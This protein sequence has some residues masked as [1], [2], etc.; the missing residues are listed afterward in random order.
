MSAETN[1]RGLLARWQRGEEAA[2]TLLFERYQQRL[3]ALLQS[4]LSRTL[5]RRVDPEDILLSAYRSFFTRVRNG[6]L[7][8]AAD[9][10][11]WPLL[12][13]I[14]LRKLARQAR[15]HSAECRNMASEQSLSTAQQEPPARSWPTAEESAALAEGVDRLLAA[16]DDNAREVVLLALHGATSPEIARSLHLHERTVRRILARITPRTP[17]ESDVPDR[18]DAEPLSTTAAAWQPQ[19]IPAG[20]V[21]YADYRLQQFVGAGAFSKVY[22]AIELPS[23]AVVAVKYLRKECWRDRRAWS[24]LIRE[25]ETLCRLDHPHLL[26]VSGWGRTPAGGV[27]LVSEFLGGGPL[28]DVNHAQSMSPGLVVDIVLAVSDAVAAAHQAGILHCDLKPTNILR[29]EDGRVVLCDFGLARYAAAPDDVPRGATAGYAAPESLCTAFGPLTE[30]T[31]VYGL[32]A[33]AYSLLTGRPPMIGRDLPETL[34]NVLSP[35]LP[36][37]PSTFRAD[38][39]PLLDAVVLKALAKSPADRFASVP[40]MAQQLP[41]R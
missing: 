11:V 34:S 8:P 12:V 40:D 26:R 31:D 27:F 25:Y 14:A 5:A 29:R 23:G 20:N 19:A 39:P 37:A 18:V 13:T 36:P 10:E 32:G 17:N 41:P 6:R 9:H 35:A 21:Q 2:A 24:G 38:C 16:L 28:C 15:R 22:R 1:N 7:T 4:R 3:L 33:L 30:R